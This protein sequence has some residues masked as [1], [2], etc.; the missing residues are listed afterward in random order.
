MLDADQAVEGVD[1]GVR[2]LREATVQPAVRQRV[3]RLGLAR[4]LVEG[5]QGEIQHALDPGEKG[6][7]VRPG[8]RL[9]A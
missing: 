1:V 5:A 8:H 2:H 4:A 7:P 3:R 9:R 6:L